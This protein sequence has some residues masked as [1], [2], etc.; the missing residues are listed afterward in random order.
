MMSHEFLQMLY[1]IGAL[2][3]MCSPYCPKQNA[4]VERHLKTVVE[5][6]YTILLH[7][8]IPTMCLEDAIYHANYICNCVATKS[9]QGVKKYDNECKCKCLVI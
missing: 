9:I 8:C 2:Q 3:K 7:S 4:I 6:A 1:S 5:M